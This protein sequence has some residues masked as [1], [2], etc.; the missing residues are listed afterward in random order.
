MLLK[1]WNQVKNVPFGKRLF[2][3]GLK[4]FVPYTGKLGAQV[5]MLEPGHCQVQLAD[6]RAVRNHL[7]SVHAM[8]LANLAEMASGMALVSGLPSSQRAILVEFNIR[9]IKKA[10]GTLLAV[11]RFELPAF[12]AE[13]DFPITVTIFNA[14][15]E[16]VSEARAVWRIGPSQ[17]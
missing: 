14:A 6:R 7:R 3:L 17:R 2:S 13:Q 9:Y 10:R 12:G 8:A 5:V 11:S 16:P 1:E 15:Q 4:W